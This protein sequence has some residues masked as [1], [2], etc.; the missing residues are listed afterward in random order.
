MDISGGAPVQEDVM[1]L[2]L[3]MSD[4]G[5]HD[6]ASFASSQLQDSAESSLQQ[7]NVLAGCIIKHIIIIT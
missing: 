3:Q 5:Q 1:K 4:V 7:H 2:A 6:A